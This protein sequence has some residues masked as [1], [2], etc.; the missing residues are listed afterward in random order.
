[1]TNGDFA[2][3]VFH[4]TT[5]ETAAKIMSSGELWS[6]Q[7]NLAG[8]G[9][10]SNVAYT[11]FTSLPRIEDEEDLHRIAMSSDGS[12]SYQTTSDR[13]VENV[14]DLRVYRSD[15]AARTATLAF[16]VPSRIIAPA[17]ILFH[18]YVY[19]NPAYY[20]I[21]GSEIVR[22]AMKSGSNLPFVDK[23]TVPRASDLKR[24]DYVVEGDA[25]TKAGLEAPMREETTDEI[26]HLVKLDRSLDIFE[27]WLKHAN[28]DQFAGHS[29]EA[30]RI[31]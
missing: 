7:W 30:R 2:L 14:L 22:V 5:K 19:P 4:H 11:Y 13:P 16:D 8:T 21:V 18:P 28:T 31:E 27:Y 20:E 6:G 23:E 17:H 3:E 24:F 9:K 12:I 25:S 1:M 26:A 10:L 29:F 15:V